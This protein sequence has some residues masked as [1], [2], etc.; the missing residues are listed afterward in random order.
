VLDEER[1]ATEVPHTRCVRESRA[2]VQTQTHTRDGARDALVTPQ[3]AVH[4]REDVSERAVP[5]LC[6][7]RRDILQLQRRGLG[8][9]QEGGCDVDALL[10]H[11][12]HE[13]QR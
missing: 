1:H 8:V 13:V 2:P 10:K 7:V 12:C 11:C 9:G 5:R 6:H 4:A 3:E